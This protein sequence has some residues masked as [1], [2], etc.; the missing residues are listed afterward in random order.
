[1][2]LV[3]DTGKSPF[4]DS[5]LNLLYRYAAH[6]KNGKRVR[7]ASSCPMLVPEDYALG[8]AQGIETPFEFRYLPPLLR[9]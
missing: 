9:R 6:Y 4:S 1:M 2:H 8:A 3:R 7:E 5:K